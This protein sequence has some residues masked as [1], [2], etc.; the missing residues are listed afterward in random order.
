ML[1]EVECKSDLII[2][3]FIINVLGECSIRVLW[4]YNIALYKL[5]GS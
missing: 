4:F 3:Q 5:G 1:S 2:K